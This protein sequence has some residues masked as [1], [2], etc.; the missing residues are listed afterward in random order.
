MLSYED[1]RRLAA[2]E[3]HLMIDDPALAR[4]FADHRSAAKASRRVAVVVLGSLC[5]FATIVGFMPPE[6][7]VLIVLVAAPVAVAAYV[8]LGRGRRHPG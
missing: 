6:V 4:R 8:L 3:Q 7:L 5:A 1:R 2:I